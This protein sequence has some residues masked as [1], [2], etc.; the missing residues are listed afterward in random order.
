[1]TE[2]WLTLNRQTAR[3]ANAA[4]GGVGRT[5]R[6]ASLQPYE[7]YLYTNCLMCLCWKEFYFSFGEGGKS[8]WYYRRRW[9]WTLG[10]SELVGKGRAMLMMDTLGSI[11]VISVYTVIITQRTVH[12]FPQNYDKITLREWKK[13]ED[14]TALKLRDKE[15]A[16]WECRLSREA[17]G[18]RVNEAEKS[19]GWGEVT[20]KQNFGLVV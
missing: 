13:G 11:S 10:K 16:A 2:T 14:W 18:E 19:E 5:A 9:W 12:F 8:C 6:E 1:M 3:T 15:K 17:L 7:R 20:E 4:W